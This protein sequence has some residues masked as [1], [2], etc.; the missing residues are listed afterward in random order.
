MPGNSEV[1]VLKPEV[2]RQIVAVVVEVLRRE[3]GI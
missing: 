1:G 3:L 2:L